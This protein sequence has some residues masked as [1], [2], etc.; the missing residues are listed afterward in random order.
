MSQVIDDTTSSINE[1]CDDASALLDETVPL[2]EFLDKQLAK[3]KE[4]ENVETDEIY[5][6][7]I[8]PS[9]PTRVEMTQIPKGYVM[10]EEIDR[11][12]LACND[13]DDVKKLMSK[14]K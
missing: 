9:S 2:G 8:M 14:L 1:T 12:I 10:D 3:A 5:D 7:P 4:L 11:E 13:R 6:S